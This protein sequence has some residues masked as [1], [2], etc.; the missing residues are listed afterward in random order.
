MVWEQLRIHSQ[1]L[2]SLVAAGD[3]ND[4]VHYVDGRYYEMLVATMES[5]IESG[6]S[7]HPLYAPGN[8]RQAP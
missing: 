8:N 5:L 2:T 3:D 7:L 6:V 1:L 4:S